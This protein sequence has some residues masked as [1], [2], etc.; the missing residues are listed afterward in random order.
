[1][2]DTNKFYTA[3]PPTCEP[4]LV[5]V[6]V[7]QLS[8]SLCK[9]KLE[10]FP[11]LMLIWMIYLVSYRGSLCWVACVGEDLCTHGLL[12]W[13]PGTVQELQEGR[14]WDGLD[15]G[16]RMQIWSGVP[17]EV[18]ALARKMCPEMFQ[19]NFPFKRLLQVRIST[20]FPRSFYL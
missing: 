2:T 20:N 1:M 7:L 10:P 14:L 18:Q 9:T 11:R 5:W 3:A 16:G 6:H 17:G 8:H 19:H 4:V 12:C 15:K 13:I